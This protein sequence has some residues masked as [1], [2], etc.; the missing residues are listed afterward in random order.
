MIVIACT[1][2]CQQPKGVAV[3]ALTADLAFCRLSATL[4]HAMGHEICNRS[5][6]A[7]S[8][9][10]T[11]PVTCRQM[12]QTGIHSHRVGAAWGSIDLVQKNPYQE[13]GIVRSRSTRAGWWQQAFICEVYGHRPAGSA[14]PAQANPQPAMTQTGKFHRNGVGERATS[15]SS[16]E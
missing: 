16:D 9:G 1:C 11:A 14:N 3:C 6:Q 5:W 4:E 2:A 7:C 15:G 8:E 13:S 12:S 10:Y